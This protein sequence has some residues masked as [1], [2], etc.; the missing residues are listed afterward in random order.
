M[1]EPLDLNRLRRHSPT[2]LVCLPDDTDP[3]DTDPGL[4]SSEVVV[5]AGVTA[6]ILR[7]LHIRTDDDPEAASSLPPPLGDPSSVEALERIQVAL[8]GAYRATPV[9]PVAPGGRYQLV[10]LRWARL[11]RADVATLGHIGR[12]LGGA[13]LPSGEELIEDVLQE[14]AGRRTPQDLVVDV[15]RLH[16]LLELEWDDDVAQLAE[17]LAPGPAARTVVLDRAGVDAYRRV[18][19]RIITIWHHGDALARW[20][21]QGD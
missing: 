15:A 20:L 18:T 21:Y 11:D 16:G 7:L 10:P 1:P 12:A 6:D 3:D 2:T 13:L 14:L 4:E 17:Q 9:Q 5:V 19:N 8:G